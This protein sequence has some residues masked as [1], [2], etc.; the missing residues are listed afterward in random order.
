M[1]R[2]LSIGNSEQ[3]IKNGKGFINKNNIYCGGLYAG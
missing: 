2:Q 1:I 3:F